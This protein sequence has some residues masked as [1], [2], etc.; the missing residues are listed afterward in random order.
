[1]PVPVAPSL[2]ART[3]DCLPVHSFRVGQLDKKHHRELK[4]GLQLLDMLLYCK[5]VSTH[6]PTRM[7]SLVY[8]YV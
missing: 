1:M 8:A 3:H 5:C 6:V 4:K 7:C 2:P